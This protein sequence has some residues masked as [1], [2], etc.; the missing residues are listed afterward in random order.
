MSLFQRVGIR[1]EQAA[2]DLRYP[3]LEILDPNRPVGPAF[4]AAARR[5]RIGPSHD[6]IDVAGQ[7]APRQRRPPRH[8]HRQ[9]GVHGRRHLGLSDRIV[10]YTIV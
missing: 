6:R 9:L 2:V 4:V 5:I 7:P 10:R 1:A 3:A 8:H